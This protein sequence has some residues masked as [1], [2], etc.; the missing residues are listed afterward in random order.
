[1]AILSQEAIERHLASLPGWQFKDNAIGRE[2]QFKEFAQAMA[3][4]N[5]VAWLAEAADHHPDMWINYRR[6]T[7][8]CSTHSEGGVTEKDLSLARAIQN[9]ASVC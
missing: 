2:F 8:V 4:V 5:W 3:F 1:M 9:A 6:V 7:L